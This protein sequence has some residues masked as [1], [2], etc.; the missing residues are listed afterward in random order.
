M[1]WPSTDTVHFDGGHLPVWDDQ[2]KTYLAER[3]IEFVKVGRHVRISESALAGFIEAGKVS[4][5]TAADVSI[6]GW[7]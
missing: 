2:A 3:R 4:P 7:A 1:W 5:P 6:H